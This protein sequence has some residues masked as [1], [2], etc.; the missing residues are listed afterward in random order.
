MAN[1]KIVSI[2]KICSFYDVPISFFDNL[3]EYELIEI[4]NVNEQKFIKEDSINKFEKIL[5]LHYDLHVNMEGIDVIT[6]L[7]N[8]IDDL[9][10]EN[11]RLKNILSF[12]EQ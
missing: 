2:H 4:V 1:P 12:Y 10:A 8:K 11:N 5:R 3:A 9:Q 6:N 7:L